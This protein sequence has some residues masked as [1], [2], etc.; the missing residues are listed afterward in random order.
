M[1]S[2]WDYIHISD[3][4]LFMQALNTWKLQCMIRHTNVTIQINVKRE[5][6]DVTS[7]IVYCTH[8]CRISF[9]PSWFRYRDVVGSVLIH[10]IYIPVVFGYPSWTLG[11]SCER[12]GSG[13]AILKDI[14][15][16]MLPSVCLRLSL[17]SQLSFIQYM[18]LR[19]FSSHN[20][21]VM[22]VRMCTLSYY[23]HQIGSM[24]R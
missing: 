10:V 21:P 24:N 3:M 12:P 17:F 23:H 9:F 14:V 19:V 18:G 5:C 22:F 7:H 11:Q 4:Q 16:Y 8:V 20:S 1:A 6:K 15:R 2:I 13:E